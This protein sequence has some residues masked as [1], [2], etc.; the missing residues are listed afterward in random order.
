MNKCQ[1]LDRVLFGSHA[2]TYTACTSVILIDS[3]GKKQK[4]KLEWSYVGV[5]IKQ[6]L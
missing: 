4:N 5:G 1:L 6:N 2:E 3:W